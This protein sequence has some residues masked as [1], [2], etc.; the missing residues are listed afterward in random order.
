MAVTARVSTVLESVGANV[1]RWRVRRGL[2]QERL[3]EL[4]DTDLRFL[5][6]IE[7]GRTNLGVHLLVRLAIALDIQP[8]ALFRPAKPMKRTTGRPPRRKRGSQ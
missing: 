7:S 3:S 6:R 2:T 4:A 1:H 8:A 5:R